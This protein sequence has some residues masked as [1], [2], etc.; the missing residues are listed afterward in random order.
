[1]PYL[2][3]LASAGF[4]GAELIAEFAAVATVLLGTLLYWIAWETLIVTRESALPADGGQMFDARFTDGV[5]H[6]TSLL[7]DLRIRRAHLLPEKVELVSRDEFLKHPSLV[8]PSNKRA[9]AFLWRG[10][11]KLAEGATVS[12]KVPR[13]LSEH[14]RAGDHTPNLGVV[15]RVAPREHQRI[16]PITMKDVA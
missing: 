6:L 2:F 10:S 8:L 13:H 15:V 11:R 7:G 1:M 5:I 9:C 4:T 12:L 16:V 14:F 3:L